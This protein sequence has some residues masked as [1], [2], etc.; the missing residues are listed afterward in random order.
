MDLKDLDF[1]LG[2]VKMDS[3]QELFTS[4]AEI[5]EQLSLLY[6]RKIS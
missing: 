1:Y 5:K 6:N 4:F 3:K 2:E